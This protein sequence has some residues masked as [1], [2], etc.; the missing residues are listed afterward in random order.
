MNR[1]MGQSVPGNASRRRGVALLLV[2]IAVAMSAVLALTFAQSQATSMGIA[3]NAQNHA[4]ARTIAETALQMAINHVRTDEDWRDTY[5][6][7]DWVVDQDLDGG[8]FTIAG[9]DEDGDLTDDDSDELTLTA[10]ASFGGVTHR[11]SALVTPGSGASD[12]TYEVGKITA[13]GTPQTVNLQSSYAEP[14]VVCTVQMVNNTKPVVV[15]V[16]N[17]GATSFDVYLQNP[18]DESIVADDVCY[19]VMEAG[20]W[21]IDGVKCEAQRYISSHT[22]ENNDWT[23]ESQEY[24]Q[25]YTA[26]VVI[27]QVMSDNDP[28]WSVFWACGN[29]RTNPPDADNLQTGKHVGEDSDASRADEMV[30]FIVFETGH[31]AM[32]GVE[33][34]A[35]RSADN[36][37]GYNNSPPYQATFESSF[38][39]PPQIV[40]ASMAGMDGTDGGYAVTYGSTI[41]S[42]Q[43]ANICVD[44]DQCKDN[45]RNHTSENL[46]VVA[47]ATPTAGAAAGATPTLIALYEFNEVEPPVP[48]A[49]GH[50]HLDETTGGG[51]AATGDDFKVRN[52]ARVDSYD[53]DA[54]PYGGDNV[55]DTAVLSTNST[56]NND[57]RIESDAVVNGSVYVGE[58]GNPSSVIDDDGTITGETGTLDQDVVIPLYAAPGGLPGNEGDKDVTNNQTWST[59]RR[60]DKLDVKNEA[61]LTIDGNIMIYCEDDFVLENEARIVL[62]EG[63]TLDLYG[64]KKMEFKNEAQLNPDTTRAADVRIYHLETSGNDLKIANEAIVC[65]TIHSNNDIKMENEAR[66]FG[67]II[68]YDDI[69]LKN[70]ARLH[71]DV[72]LASAGASTPPA[73][74]DVE[75]S[76]GTYAGGVGLGYT[77]QHGTSAY[78]DGNDDY[79]E[80]PHDDS[81]L[82]DA[83]S[84]AMWIRPAQ[85]SSRMEFFSKDSQGYDTGGHL[86]MHV[87]G[88]KIKVRLQSDNDETWVEGGSITANQ[89]HHV[90]FSWGVLG[91]ML[92]VDGT[93]VDSAEYTGGLGDTSGGAGN[94]EPIVIGANSWESDNL[95]ATPLED[96]FEGYID[97][98][99]IYDQ[100][101]NETQVNNVMAGIEPGP[102]NTKGY[103]VEDTSGYG[104]PLNLTVEDTSVITWIDG[105]GLRFDGDGRAQS[106]AA[107]K[108]YDALTATDEFSLELLITP[109]NTFQ[110]GPA[111]V[112]GMSGGS[113]DRNFTFGQSGQIAGAR[114]RTSDTVSNGTPDIETGDVLDSD[115][116]MHF[117]VAFDGQTV[118]IY[119]DGELEVEGERTGDLTTWSN[120]YSLVMGNEVGADRA[121]R[122]ALHRIAVYDRAFNAAQAANVH[123]GE[124]PGDGAPEA[125]GFAYRWLEMQ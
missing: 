15:R 92:H 28:D 34:D 106:T 51:G 118:T 4:H 121:W 103:I 47:F 93:L 104:D 46:A 72:A 87:E 117:V 14:V 86:T 7:G 99:R 101:F 21:E 107:T 95:A 73:A 17:V 52:E 44:E 25:E 35:T 3:D 102:G 71:L 105:G 116:Q 23:G 79:L 88:G 64:E 53:A 2:L 89:W 9:V 74:D 29:K 40:L 18:S 69:E 5:T 31:G 90:A 82:L 119:R 20:A 45:E 67:R 65:A 59:D 1:K 50:W 39:Q 27:G 98:V 6:S 37:Q 8:T 113:A 80:I 97:D 112:F 33:M 91:M 109:D 94:Y 75:T 123:N 60:F 114:V 70:E 62:T 63:S 48:Q 84:V 124:A 57:V 54:G 24:L 43:Q 61:V 78:F 30:G 16:S 42:T 26:P 81:Y 77:G 115:T 32:G 13:T 66:V 83:G 85:T 76:D 12:A 122:G 10:I 96:Y 125:T 22:G 38:A 110:S 49:I 68:A 41:A 108:I 19:M 56:S 120:L 100:P 111:C 36:V 58:G 55:L 11:V